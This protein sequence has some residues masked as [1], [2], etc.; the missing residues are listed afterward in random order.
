LEGYQKFEYII[1]RRLTEDIPY[2]LKVAM[3]QWKTIA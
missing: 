3:S 2:P 1:E